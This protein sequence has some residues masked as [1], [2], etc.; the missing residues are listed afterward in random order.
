M[1]DRVPPRRVGRA[2]S[3]ISLKSP[4]LQLVAGT[5][6]GQGIVLAI[7]PLVTRL[8]LP[9]HFGVLAVFV[10]LSGFLAVAST[11]R[12]ELAIPLPVEDREAA[13]VMLC[14]AL[15][16]VAT[17]L[18][19]A[20]GVWVL[21]RRF[22][23]AMSVPDLEHYLWIAPVTVLGIGLHR[24]GTYWS[25][26][27]Q[28]LR[29]LSTTAVWRGVAHA[30]VQVSGGL[31]RPTPGGLIVGAFAGRATGAVRLLRVARRSAPDS[32]RG[33]TWA[34]I[35][36]AGNRYR[37]F[38]LISIWSALINTAGSSVVPILLARSYGPAVAGYYA[39][40]ER[41]VLAPVSTVGDAIRNIYVA[42]ASRALR[43]SEDSLRAVFFSMA[44]RLGAIAVIPFALLG[45]AAPPLFVLILGATWGEAGLYARIMAPM[46]LV[47]FIVVPISQTLYILE[48]QGAQLLWDFARLLVTAAIFISPPANLT[49]T[50]AIGAYSTA[51]TVCYITLFG[52]CVLYLPRGRA[53]DG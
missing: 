10:S 39:V 28:Q 18:L 16:T 7:T 5:A 19:T 14:A 44:R 22:A 17:A 50:T 51:L 13:S 30:L 29:V 32:F 24:A 41:V 20:L 4:S 36:R 35:L 1:S 33:I 37:R 9:E 2:M 11:F 27:T 34:E 52:L 45:F 3:R 25:L 43:A 38:P 49:P 47:Q 46:F 31:L 53:V 40:A 48:R 8:Y 23:I 15:G 26:R 42:Q 21:G 6:A 12:Y